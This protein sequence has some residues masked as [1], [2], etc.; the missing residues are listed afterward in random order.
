MELFR[1]RNCYQWPVSVGRLN[2]AKY[3]K[4]RSLFV[5]GV[6]CQWWVGSCTFGW[7]QKRS[8]EQTC[9]RPGGINVAEE[10]AGKRFKVEWDF[11]E[12][13]IKKFVN[14]E[15]EIYIWK[16]LRLEINATLPSVGCRW[17]TFGERSNQNQVSSN[18]DVKFWA[19]MISVR[20]ESFTMI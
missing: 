7:K 16:E 19:P 10:S 15:K 18:C 17:R 11:E 1:F 4:I 13:K 3:V 6:Q 20:Y 14:L 8:T 12:E 9:Q 5:V 2:E